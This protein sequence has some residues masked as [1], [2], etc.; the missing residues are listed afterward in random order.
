MR[1][2]RP[3]TFSRTAGR[4]GRPRAGAR[5]GGDRRPR[6]PRSSGVGLGVPRSLI[7]DSDRGGGRD[8]Q[9][10]ELSGRTRMGNTSR[11]LPQAGYK[12]TVGSRMERP[13]RRLWCPPLKL[14]PATAGPSGS[15]RRTTAVRG[16]SGRVD[17]NRYRYNDLGKEHSRTGR[18][19]PLSGACASPRLLADM[20]ASRHNGERPPTRRC[21]PDPAQ[22]ARRPDPR[23]RSSA[24]TRR[25]PGRSASGA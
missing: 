23:R 4:V 5:P 6:R 21:G 17:L 25:S 19:D 22:R 11:R 7:Y 8:L 1:S 14:G 18:H 20:E 2:P 9:L 13:T 3:T 10:A 16:I 15:T 24:T 12:V